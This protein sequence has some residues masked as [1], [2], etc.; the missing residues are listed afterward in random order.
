MARRIAERNDLKLLELLEHLKAFLRPEIPDERNAA[1][2]YTQAL[3]VLGSCAHKGPEKGAYDAIL[4]SNQAPSPEDLNTLTHFFEKHSEALDKGYQLLRDAAKRPECLF[5]SQADG[6]VAAGRGDMLKMATTC[7]VLRVRAI[8]Q[9]H[10]GDARGA[11]D[12]LASAMALA[13]AVRTDPSLASE[14]IARSME[15]MTADVLQQLPHLSTVALAGQLQDIEPEY[16]RRTN[17]HALL[18][19]VHELVSTYLTAQNKLPSADPDKVGF[20]F[21]LPEAPTADDMKAF[22]D[23]T[24]DIFP[25]LMRPYW[26]VRIETKALIDKYRLLPDEYVP[27][28]RF[29]LS[30]GWD[31]IGRST[32]EAEARGIMLRMAVELERYRERKGAYPPALEALQGALWKD[33]FSGQSF[34]YQLQGAGF[35]LQ[36]SGHPPGEQPVTW[37]A[38]Q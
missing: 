8:V 32:A 5:P 3:D 31:R 10:S 2:L 37:Q 4:W 35:S 6:A 28:T 7:E 24:A 27:Y 26:E 23:C 36:T 19:A 29:I 9:A 38:P 16:V 21:G 34:V 18:G 20:N 17:Q 22:V 30:G 11:S 25:L 1:V 14:M 15:K 12:T 33:P 13:R